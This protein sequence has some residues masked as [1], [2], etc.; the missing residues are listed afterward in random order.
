MS[1]L[2]VLSAPQRVSFASGPATGVRNLTFGQFDPS[3]GTLDAVVIT[4]GA[5]FGGTES[6]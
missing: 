6:L 5:T 1:T 2:D 3:L 4:L